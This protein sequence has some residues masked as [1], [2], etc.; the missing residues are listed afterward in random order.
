MDERGAIKKKIKSKIKNLKNR[1]A[2]LFACFTYFAVQSHAADTFTILKPAAFA[3]HIERFNTMEPETVVN[4]IPNSNSWTWLQK[5]IPLFECPDP[6]IQEI[7]YFRWWSFRKHIKQTPKGFVITEFLTPVNHAGEFNTIS[8]ATS[9]HLAEGRWLRDDRYLNDYTQF[10]LRG[11][12]GKPQPH[13][14]K[15]SSW[16]AAAAWD[17]YLVNGDQKFLTQFLPDLVADYRLWETER[18]LPSGLFWQYDVRD[19]M[20][21][22]ISGSRTAKNIR[23]TINSYMFAN[24]RAIADIATLANKPKLAAEFRNKAATLKHLVQQ[25]LWDTNANFFKVLVASTN[26]SVPSVPS[27]L[28]SARESI[29]YIP[30]MF[31]LPDPQSSHAT[32]FAQLT[33]PQGF[34]APFGLTTA[35]RRHPQFRN[36]GVG[37]CEW[38]GAIWPFASSQTLYALANYLRLPDSNSPVTNHQSRITHF[39][40]FLTYTRSQYAHGKPYLGEYLDEV[41]GDWINRNDRSRYY[42]HSTY[43]DLLLTGVIGLIPRADDIVEINPLLPRDTWDWFCLDGVKYHGHMLTVLWDKDGSRYGRGAGLRVLANGKQ[44]ASSEKLERITGKLP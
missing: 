44:I 36:R 6:A 23:P 38:D 30:W 40:S 3:H 16:F 31:A 2:F 32:A 8:C 7:Y 11:D 39:S 34:S 42:N 18:Q 10:W 41:T 22:S 15:F 43:A 9:L 1:V 33:D 13:F 5:N 24:A 17:R 4:D 21:E 20:E 35:E 25:H 37:T 14:H 29:G 26:S 19:G 28:S 27:V 12:N